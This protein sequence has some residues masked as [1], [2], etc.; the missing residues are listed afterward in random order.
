[1]QL[2]MQAGEG[3]WDRDSFSAGAYWF[4]PGN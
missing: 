2:T 4:W 3:D 1:M